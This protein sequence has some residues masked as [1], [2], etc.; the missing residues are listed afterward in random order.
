ML[1]LINM[2]LRVRKNLAVP[3]GVSFEQGLLP[4]AKKRAKLRHR[5]LSAHIC[6]LI[7]ADLEQSTKNSVASPTN[8]GE[9]K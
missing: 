6:D 1:R 4:K 3:H 8:Q 7:R 2:K 9:A 5:S